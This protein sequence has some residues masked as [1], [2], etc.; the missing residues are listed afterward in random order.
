MQADPMGVV[1]GAAVLNTA[2]DPYQ[3]FT[4]I[5]KRPSESRKQSFDFAESRLS[6]LSPE[7]L[8]RSFSRENQLFKLVVGTAA[9]PVF[10]ERQ[11]L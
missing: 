10:D 1:N 4:K 5:S 2:G 7:S 8:E 3:P 9:F 6:F 11:L